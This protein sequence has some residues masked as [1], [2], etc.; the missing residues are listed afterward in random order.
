MT[1]VR[2]LLTPNLEV[3]AVGVGVHPAW[4]ASQ[5]LSARRDLLLAQLSPLQSLLPA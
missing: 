3:E 1:V 5:P 4:A 2:H